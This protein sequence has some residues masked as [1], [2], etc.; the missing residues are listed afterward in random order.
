MSRVHSRVRETDSG[1]C[2]PPGAAP[3]G[4]QGR[5]RRWRKGRRMGGE[6]P[7]HGPGPGTAVAAPRSGC[8]GAAS[9][10]R[11]PTERLPHFRDTAPTL[12]LLTSLSSYFCRPGCRK[13][14]GAQAPRFEMTFVYEGISASRVLLRNKQHYWE[15]GWVMLRAEVVP[16]PLSGQTGRSGDSS[17]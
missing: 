14:P 5:A 10:S 12:P 16:L 15:V 4:T 6:R 2:P 8:T 7:A 9:S 17:R 11:K 3:S 13:A 1:C